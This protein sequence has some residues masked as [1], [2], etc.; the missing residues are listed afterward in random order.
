M[1]RNCSIARLIAKCHLMGTNIIL[2]KYWYNSNYTSDKSGTY[3]GRTKYL[4]STEHSMY[5]KN[6]Y[7]LVPYFKRLLQYNGVN[8]DCQMLC[9]IPE[10][11][12]LSTN[13]FGTSMETFFIRPAIY[14]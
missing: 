14:S 3:E 9:E 8:F 4:C 6:R 10:V 1:A 5:D 7:F 11:E 13:L 12:C 2:W